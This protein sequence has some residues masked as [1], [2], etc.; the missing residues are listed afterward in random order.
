MSI[1]RR[2]FLIGTAGLA[3]SVLPGSLMAS[4]RPCPPATLSV[5]QGQ[6][7]S[8][9]CQ[10]SVLAREAQAVKDSSPNAPAWAEAPIGQSTLNGKVHYWGE[11]A[12]GGEVLAGRAPFMAPNPVSDQYNI[13]D[14]GGKAHWDTA[15]G[16]WWFSG[17]PTGNQDPASPTIVRYRPSDDRFAH[18]QGRASMQG[19]IWPPYGHAHSFDAADL[20]VSG[21]RIWRHL[22]HHGGNPVFNFALG[23]FDIDTNESGTV[24][25]DQYAVDN[26]PTVSFMPDNR[27]LHVIRPQSNSSA[28]IRRFDVD[29]RAW[30]EPLKG[31]SGD[32]GPSCYLKGKIYGTTSDR[33][34]YAIL[35]S[36]AILARAPLPILMDRSAAVAHA[37]LCPIGNFVFAF[38]GNGDIW[39]YDPEADSWGGSRYDSIPW[40][41]PHHKF[42]P[43]AS[44]W[45][46]MS[47]TCAGPVPQ[48]GVAMLC[49]PSVWTSKASV[50]ARVFLWKP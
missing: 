27:V 38:C 40:R 10:E 25:G 32:C 4:I 3:G 39:R 47:A 18:W 2:E 36:G 11:A 15:R 19:G 34:F 1:R 20:D 17:G 45:N 23:W 16:D 21:R 41:W 50:D 44:N 35:P 12:S 9:S 42:D 29:K 24:P 43:A 5:A 7:L 46:Y 30:I 49:S 31:P 37:I 6:A 8:A 22:G 48:H 26:W 14:W 13:L 28:N 33:N